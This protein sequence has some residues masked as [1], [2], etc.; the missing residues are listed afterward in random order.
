MRKG[1]VIA[2]LIAV[3]VLAGA[4][5]AFA[6]NNAQTEEVEVAE[7]T[8]E[9]LSVVVAAS[10]RVE[11]DNR[12][13]VY[14]PTAGTLSSV[15]VTEGARVC[16]GQ[17]LAYMDT[18]ALEAQ[19]AQADAA[20]LGAKAQ[21]DAAATSVP[22]P[23]D[24]QAAQAAVDAAYSAYQLAN[25]QYEA[26]KA[27]AGA[28][29]SGD[30]AGAQTAVAAAEASAQ[31]AQAAYDNF[32]N[33]VYLPTP[34]PRP[35]ELET[36]LA[37]LGFARDQATVNLLSARQTLAAL[38][39][40]SDNTAA[41]AAAKA[42]RDQAYAAYLGTV[43][44]REALA[45]ASS[46]SSALSSAD[47]AVDAAAQA[48]ALAEETLAAATIT[49]PAD[50]YV[51]FNTG[52]ASLGGASGLSALAGG[53]TAA[54]SGG[55][56]APGSTVSPASP[57]FTI[58]SLETLAFTALVDETDVTSIEPGMDA[59]VQLD[60]IAAEEFDAEVVS[61]GLEASTTSTGGTAFA[62]KLTFST[63]GLPVLLGMNGSVAINI[64]TI[65]DV[66]TIPV[67]ALV[68]EE[69]VDYVYVVEDGHLRRMELEV[70]RFTDTSIEVLSGVEPGDQVVVSG[71]GDM[72]DGNRVS[73]R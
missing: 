18:D 64:E 33:N 1:R 37:A 11:D 54:P 39:A 14:P 30:I 47:A 7:V 17:V 46:V 61:V 57:P 27:G 52:S 62:V 50:G 72:Q 65:G 48:K 29:S 55:D 58:V 21:R 41:V 26:V 19:A 63:R 24:R 15:E 56:L 38:I 4:I 9:D 16:A 51:L 70:G 66:V 10:G 2:A 59:V 67:E 32:Y 53:A 25:A 43:S 31:A 34:E 69:G 40:A 45:K 6:I 8:R 44:Q 20:Y 22:G 35:A 36:A 13:D 28:P 68:E 3:L 12:I 23:A 71:I 42:A 60:G 49:A 73:V 5:A